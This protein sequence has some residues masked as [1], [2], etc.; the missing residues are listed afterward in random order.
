MV[1]DDD[2]PLVDFLETLL[3]ATK[4]S[5]VQVV[6]LPDLLEDIIHEFRFMEQRLEAYRQSVLWYGGCSKDEH[7]LI[8]VT[9]LIESENPHND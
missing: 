9:T 7:P 5:K 6:A 2:I 1:Y 4:N 3:E 8:K